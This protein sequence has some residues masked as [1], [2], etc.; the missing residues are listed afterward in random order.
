MNRM[1]QFKCKNIII[2]STISFFVNIS[3]GVNICGIPYTN[4]FPH[5]AATL[6]KSTLQIIK[7]KSRFIKPFCNI[8]FYQRCIQ[9]TVRNRVAGIKDV[10]FGYITK[11]DRTKFHAKSTLSSCFLAHVPRESLS[12][13]TCHWNHENVV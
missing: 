11:A 2:N 5:T 8:I 3:E 1:F 9:T 7:R 10:Q 4:F 13:F 12:L 6:S